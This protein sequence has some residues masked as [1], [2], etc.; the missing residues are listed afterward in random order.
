MGDIP[1]RL[2]TMK[3][4]HGFVCDVYG[5]MRILSFPLDTLI[6]EGE[7]GIGID[8][9]SIK[10]FAEIEDSDILGIPE[11][12]HVIM[13]PEMAEALI[14]LRTYR[15]DGNPLPT[16]PRNVAYRTENMLSS[17]GLNAFIRPEME[18]FVFKKDEDPLNVRNLGG[19]QY[20]LPP[21]EDEM[22]EYRKKLA[23]LLME[24]GIGVRYQHHENA[25]GQMEIELTPTEGLIRTGD[26]ILMHKH[27]SK[28]LAKKY[29]V[30]VTY[31]PKPIPTEAGSGM[32]MHIYL[33]KNGKNVFYSKDEW[34]GLSQTARYFIG[35]ILEH[36]RGFTAIT[37]PT[38][39]SYKRIAGGLEAPAYVAWG[40]RNRSALLRVPA[41]KS[42]PDVEIR[43]PDPSANPYLAES[44]I[45]Q[46]GLDGIKKKIEPPEPIE[47]NIYHMNASKRK[48]LGIKMLPMN[49][50][51]A[52]EEMKSDEVVQRALGPIYD[53]FV[54]LKEEEWSRFIGNTSP[55][56]I[57]RY[58]D[59]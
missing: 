11:M 2:H 30:K 5:R 51:D 6:K 9:S 21:S 28:M 13:L 40:A 17:E 45:I 58:F 12:E 36:V 37:N 44:V 24:A 15:E 4:F 8:G 20:F 31:M 25:Y 52:V 46:A 18:F 35:G 41:G 49:L 1:D 50:H 53:V 47:E 55:W 16:D 26:Y 10:G 23:E 42:N 48:K 43:N 34:H 59:V 22:A 14:P 57:E 29:D 32:H 38:V 56:E 39:N 33:E 7:K 19:P 54:S 3:W 27:L